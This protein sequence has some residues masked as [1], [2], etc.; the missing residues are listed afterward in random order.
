[1]HPAGCVRTLKEHGSKV[2]HRRGGCRRVPN[3]YRFFGHV[4][5]NGF[6]GHDFPKLIYY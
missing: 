2:K 4:D 6:N 5:E 3:V 1:M